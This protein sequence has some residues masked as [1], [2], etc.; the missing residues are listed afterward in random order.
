MI[1]YAVI[2]QARLNSTRLPGKVLMDINGQRLIDRVIDNAREA[3]GHVIV[4]TPDQEIADIAEEHNVL[5][6]IGSEYDVLDRYY[7]AAKHFAVENLIRITADNP[8]IPP[9]LINKLIEYHRRFRHLDWVSNCRLK[10]TYPIG[11][12]AELVR[13]EALEIAWQE[14]IEA[15]DRES[16]TSYIYNHA[17]KF[18]L[19]VLENDIDLSFIRLTVDTLQDLERVRMLC[20]R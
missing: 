10:T 3:I 20:T 11:V 12:D 17:E 19:S 6:F 2:I 15:Y 16:V 18:K 5:S 1:E 8:Y 13:F 14:A 7:Q 4:A 9:A